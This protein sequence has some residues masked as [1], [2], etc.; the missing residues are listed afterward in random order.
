MK[1]RELIQHNL[2]LKQ[3][4]L[5]LKEELGKKYTDNVIG[6]DGGLKETMDLIRRVA[7]S[8]STILLLGETGVGKEIARRQRSR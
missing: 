5:F 7:P 1:H 3:D 8:S 4:N 2:I 6:G